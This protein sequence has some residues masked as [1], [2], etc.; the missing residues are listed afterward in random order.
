MVAGLAVFRLVALAG[1]LHLLALPVATPAAA[2]ADLTQFDAVVAVSD[3][4]LPALLGSGSL[5]DY[6]V[7]SPTDLGWDEAALTDLGLFRDDSVL[8]PAMLGLDTPGQR[9]PV[10]INPP[11]PGFT[12]VN[13][14]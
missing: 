1:L 11:G 2:D 9:G 6:A 14:R 13:V 8:T 3:V 10:V 7:V 12:T 5:G 4:D